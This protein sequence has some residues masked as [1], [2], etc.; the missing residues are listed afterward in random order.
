MAMRSVGALKYLEGAAKGGQFIRNGVTPLM[1]GNGRC[2]TSVNMPR[3]HACEYLV[4]INKLMLQRH[5]HVATYQG[6]T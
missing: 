4:F 5:H 1:P 2:P 6:A 3:Q